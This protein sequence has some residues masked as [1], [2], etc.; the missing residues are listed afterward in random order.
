M[1]GMIFIK[2]NVPSLKNSKI[3]T[4]HGVFP[5]KT[6]KHYLQ[7][8]GIKQYGHDYVENYVTRPN[9]FQYAV[10]GYFS[11]IKDYP[12]LLGMHF[13][14][15]SKRKFDLINAAQIICDL[16]VAHRY[17]PDDC[18]DYLVPIPL[19]IDGRWF[20]YDKENP[21]VWLKVLHEVHVF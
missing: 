8:M 7:N 13:V 12:V 3:V 9:L 20:S 5:S 19:Q 11:D 2:L 6:C 16:L 10:G 14:R 18:A 4:P 17:I 15:D 1:T 21:G